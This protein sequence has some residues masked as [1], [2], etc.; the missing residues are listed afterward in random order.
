MCIAKPLLAALLVLLN[1]PLLYASES[2][3]SLTEQELAWIHEHPKV[4]VGVTSDWTPFNFVSEEGQ[5]D[6][7]S[8]DYLKLISKKTG[9]NFTSH[10]GE[11]SHNL[12]KI[13]DKKLD[14]L[15]AVYFTEE[16]TQYLTFS[17][18]YF[19]MLDY[20][21]IRDDLDVEVLADL[22]GK[23]IAIPKDYAHIEVLKEH[24]PKIH[25]VTVN[26]FIGA[27]EAV[28]ENRADILYDTYGSLTYTLKKEGINTIVPFKSTRHLGKKAIQIAIQKDK[29]IL[30]GIITKGLDAISVAE[31][32][33]VYERWLGGRQSPEPTPIL[34]FS[35]QESQWLNDHP[36]IRF[37]G[38]PNWLPYEAFDPYGNYIGIVA[39]HLKI[40]EQKLG[41]KVEIIRTKTWRESV[42]KVKLGEIDILSETSD[43]ELK[44]LLTFTEDYISSPIV[45]VMGND[46]D[47]VESINQIKKK[48]IAVIKD[49]GYISEIINKH[50]DLKLHYVDTIQEGL[51]AVATGEVDVLLATLAQASYHISE[52]GINNI[53]IVGKTEFTTK[54]AFGMSAEFSPLVPLFNRALH[55]LSLNEK[56]IIFDSWGKQKFAERADYRWL[57]KIIGA[58]LLFMLIMFY[59]NR[60]LAKE[61]ALRSEVE[62]QTKMLIDSLPIQIVVTSYNGQLLSAN[63]QALNDYNL[64]YRGL[65]QYNILEF[66][67]NMHDRREVIKE[68]KEHVKIEQKIIPMKQSD[69]KIYSMMVSIMPI[70][71]HKQRALLSI[72]INI[73]E[74]L[75]MEAE[76]QSAKSHAESANQAKSVFLANMSHEIRTP[77]NA[78][79]GFTELLNEHI[80]EPKLKSFVKTIQAAGN[81]L[82]VLINDI[83]DLSKI[84]AGKLKINKAP[85]NPHDLFT[86]LGNIF[87]LKM[88]EKNIDFILDVD[89]IIPQGLYLDVTRLRQVLLNLIGNAVKF[90]DNGSIKITVRI[91]KEDK[92]PNKVD[93]LIDVEDSGIGI[94]EDQQELIFQDFEQSD[95]QDMGKYGGTGL[96]LSISKRLIEM[97][98]GQLLLQSQ[99]GVG[100]IFTVK[101][102]ALDTTS[103]PIESELE[104]PTNKVQ[105]EF[106]SAKILIVDD[107]KDN[108]S[109]LLAHFNDTALQATTAVNGLEAVNLVKQQLFDLILMDIRMPVMNGY[110]AAEEIKAM[111]NVPIVALTASVM[112]DDFERKK[113]DNFDGYLR[114]P[115]LRADLMKELC[116]FLAFTEKECEERQ[117]QTFSLTPEEKMRLPDVL[118]ALD[119]LSSL[120][121]AGVKSNNIS[122]IELFSDALSIV[123][124]QYPI[125]LVAEYTMPLK[126][127]IDSFDIAAIKQILSSYPDLT[128]QLRALDEQ[129]KPTT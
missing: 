17:P 28:L 105:I 52:L 57:A 56:Q 54:L 46:E 30:A 19:E 24:F 96:G 125:T 100:S 91:E 13:K 59:W 12:Q 55:S 78:I 120:Y 8:S 108:Q 99:S 89:P 4:S 114:K 102:M 39:D 98:G 69:G 20:F 43:S 90:T 41:I 48:E 22:D 71:Y 74:R 124:K 26:T 9:L 110:Q 122:D 40:I 11:W 68:L 45:M 88:R 97:M 64:I 44:S 84:E 126:Q 7:I 25:I 31:K 83:L 101:L 119:K 10:I 94:S 75:E 118:V 113:S 29:P 15:P 93:L 1:L 60:K 47:Y 87:M 70:K 82:L 65:D 36:I 32:T 23:R 53:R 85:C 35:E 92:I 109:L 21:F 79:I 129:Q 42:E 127:A 73:T 111:S 128:L 3:L 76:L 27:I 112:T 37:A 61:V 66:Y 116:K 16:R 107:V 6:G 67:A 86:E 38:D 58:L 51:A 18:P 103:L 49:Y 117:Q 33:E 104:P 5:H 106:K 50:P 95:G 72:A 14:L 77:M 123:T 115:V 80:E 2:S 121:D 62:Q 81:N 63:P 34:L